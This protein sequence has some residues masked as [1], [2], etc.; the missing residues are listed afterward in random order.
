MARDPYRYFRVEA[1]DLLDQ[2]GKG[3]LEFDKG[4]A[5][6]ELIALMLRLAHTLKGAA[7]VV[8][9][10]EIADHAHA[11]EDALAPFR[12]NGTAV[13]REGIDAV[14]RA[15]D[16][17]SLRVAALDPQ[18]PGDAA[19]GSKITADADR[20]GTVQNT[21]SMTNSFAEPVRTNIDEMDML[22]DGVSEAGVQLAALRRGIGTLQRSRRLAQILEE[23]WNAPRAERMGGAAPKLGSMI[24]ELRGVAEGLHRDFSDGIEQLDRELAQVREAAE[25][26]RLLPASFMFVSLERAARDAGQSLGKR[27][28]FV[29]S[30][31]E[32]RLDA[33]VFGAVQSALVQAVRNAVAHGI[34]S[35]AEREAADKP[36]EGRVS[37]E[38]RRRG[39]QAVFVCRDDG[40][41]IDLEAVRR[42]VEAKGLRAADAAKLG[43]EELLRRLLGGGLT[44]SSAVTQLAGR[45]IGLDVVREAAA[46]LRGEVSIRTDSGLGTTLEIVVPISLA[47]VDALIVEAG[48]RTVAI[49]LDAVKRTVRV[50]AD[51]LAQSAQGASILFEG[52]VIPF[53]PLERALRRTTQSRDIAR[54][55]SAVVI[56]GA[57]AL[58]AVGV[59][60]LR[61]TQNLV[62]RPLPEFTP[63]DPVVAGASLDAEGHPQLVLDPQGLVEHVCRAGPVLA[64]TNSARA[65]IL[66]IDDSLTTRML[67]QSI[68]ESAGYEVD[69]ATSGEDG[70]ERALK[71]RYALF[72]VDVEMP[73]MDGFTFIERTRKDPSLRDIPAILVTS[74]A[75]A[76]DRQRG[77]RAG[78]RAYIVKGEFDQTELL[79]K[80]RLLAGPQ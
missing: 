61:G 36:A 22:L 18:S 76:E 75:S 80:I 42:A 15:L 9:Q 41:G 66:V 24:A 71:R 26:L 63:G 21:P 14:L 10:R 47:A 4:T 12:E 59:E 51:D 34:E 46:R 54:S 8:K 27:I 73:G 74:R 52:R 16:E 23:Q 78:A 3:A 30:G 55:W 38:V 56:E 58:A 57:N 11:I 20:G 5:A 40:R 1:R 19:S 33:Q 13:S 60:R 45:G 2:L 49:P 43:T 32:V 31:G 79:E 6:P 25:R 69:L 77:Q 28:A 67:E 64:A 35:R 72:L 29:T 17:I 65:P 39:H 48:G 7:R 37:V 50:A 53:A 68:L 44:T 62:L 70:L